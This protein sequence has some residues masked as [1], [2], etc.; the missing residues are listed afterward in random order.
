M[1]YQLWYIYH[2]AFLLVTPQFAVVFDWFADGPDTPPRN[3]GYVPR[4]MRLIRPDQKLYVLVS[5]HHKDH[6]TSRIFGWNRFHSDIHYF[7]SPDVARAS[8][9]ILTPG[10]LYRGP[11]PDPEHVKVIEPGEICI[12]KFLTVEAFASTDIG[13]SYLLTIGKK[14][15]FHAGDLNA[16]IWKD[17]STEQEVAEALDLYRQILSNVALAAP[18]MEVCMFPVDSRIGTDYFT[19]ARLLLHA[20]DVAHFFPMHF[21]LADDAASLEQRR[22]DALAFSRYANPDRGEYIG[23]TQPYSCFASKVKN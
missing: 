10:S 14:K 16:W 8:R 4:F 2:D 21:C 3:P 7:I 13:N 19:G 20:I 9:H 11:R 23:L 12:D 18:K 6:F 17:E 15:F 5:H 1:E 22:I